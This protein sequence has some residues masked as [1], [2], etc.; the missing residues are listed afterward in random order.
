MIAG[1]AALA[2][3]AQQ[4]PACAP[5]HAAMGHCTAPAKAPTPA[6]GGPA[7]TDLPAGDAPPPPAPR[8]D[9]ADRIFGAAAMDAPRRHLYRMHG[10]DRWSQV[11]VN[12]AEV[13]PRAGRNGYRWDAEGWFG[14][15]RDRL[16]VRTEGEGTTGRAPEEAEVQALYSRAIGPYFNLQAGARHDITPNPSRSHAVLGVEG[17]APYWFDVEAAVFLSNRGELTARAEASYD[18]FVTQRLILQPR[19]ELNLSAQRVPAL[20]LGGG[21]TDVELGLR[22]RYEIVRE[23]APYV[24]VNW[25]RRLG[26][27]ARLARA[28]GSE[29]GDVNLVL[30][31]RTWF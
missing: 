22:L 11:M 3:A 29:G 10:G 26:E 14:G 24:G 2:L 20:R 4:A 5:E 23:F 18:L 30:G 27:T 19:G 6:P 8:V 9:A 12:L 16:V 31:V 21:L 7:G 28:G 25:T 13:A 1:L 17:L 15:D